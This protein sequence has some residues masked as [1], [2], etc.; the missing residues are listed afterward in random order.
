MDSKAYMILKYRII[1]GQE[2]CVQ[3]DSHE[4][5]TIDHIIPTSQGGSEKNRNLQ[6]LCVRCHAK[7]NGDLSVPNPIG[8]KPKLNPYIRKRKRKW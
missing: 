5:L 1:H 8:T 7:K 4:D 2:K 3:C 6:V